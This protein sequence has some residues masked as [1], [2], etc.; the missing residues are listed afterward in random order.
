MD[1]VQ[2]SMSN[3]FL[4]AIEGIDGSGKSSVINYL[5]EERE[6]LFLTQE[7]SNL[8]TGDWTRQCIEYDQTAP[9]TDFFMFQAD[10]AE[11][12][13]RQI[14]PALN[15]GQTVVVDRY[16]DSTRAYQQEALKD[17]VDSPRSFIDDTMREFPEPDITAYIDVP[18]SVVAERTESDDKYERLP[19]LESVRE[20][21]LE[22]ESE[23]GNFK[24]VEGNRSI[25]EVAAG[26][27]NIINIFTE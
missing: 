18:V 8:W 7:P 17:D 25:D 3:G 2:N 13:R 5:A 26:V 20:N 19:F 14:L 6:E 21:Y 9:L 23:F 16:V 12:L 27:E 11:H 4:I 1:A 15:N 24:R 22:L 10:R